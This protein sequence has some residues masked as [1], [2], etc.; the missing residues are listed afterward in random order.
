VLVDPPELRTEHPAVERTGPT[1]PVRRATGTTVAQAAG[2]G[3]TVSGLPDEVPDEVP[4]GLPDEVRPD[5]PHPLELAAWRREIRRLAATIAVDPDH[6]AAAIP[7]LERVSHSDKASRSQLGMLRAQLERLRLEGGTAMVMAWFATLRDSATRKDAW[8]TSTLRALEELLVT[9]P[10][11]V[12]QTLKLTAEQHDR[13]TLAPGR[14]DMIKQHLTR[15]A[16]AVLVDELI[17]Q[18][19]AEQEIAMVQ[20]GVPS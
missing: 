12:W 2:T 8:E 7:G 14:E 3:A 17:R 10:E 16:V 20:E 5:Q 18:V 13:L 6:R 19:R 4:D 15:E 11:T 1:L 9:A